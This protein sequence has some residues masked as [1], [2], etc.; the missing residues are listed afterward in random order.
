[1]R[2]HHLLSHGQQLVDFT[3]SP[4]WTSHVDVAA[5]T[6][7]APGTT[8]PSNRIYMK[9]EHQYVYGSK[10]DIWVRNI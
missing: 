6:S 7:P 4:V 8:M 2:L 5:L 10:G 3:V 9:M 1:M